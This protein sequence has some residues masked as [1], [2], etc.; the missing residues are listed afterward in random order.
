MTGWR[1]ASPTRQVGGWLAGRAAWR[2]ITNVAPQCCCVSNWTCL[3]GCLPASAAAAAA[4]AA[5]SKLAT[6]KLAACRPAAADDEDNFVVGLGVDCTGVELPVL[7]P[8]D[9]T[10]PDL[11]PQPLLLVRAYC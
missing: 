3:P 10:A 6:S 2:L 1:S 8:T 11:P 4:A 7:H 5:T 9:E